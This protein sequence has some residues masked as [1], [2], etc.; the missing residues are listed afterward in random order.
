VIFISGGEVEDGMAALS[1]RIRALLWQLYDG[2][3]VFIAFP[4]APS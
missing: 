1:P 3:K 2:G 4:P